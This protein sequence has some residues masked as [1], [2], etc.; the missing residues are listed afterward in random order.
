MG[1]RKMKKIIID[2]VS[3]FKLFTSLHLSVST[4]SQQKNFVFAEK[5]FQK[6]Y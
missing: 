1:I 4:I 2:K 5:K 3:L 6:N